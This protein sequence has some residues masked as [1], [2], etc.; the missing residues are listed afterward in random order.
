MRALHDLVEELRLVGPSPD[1][2]DAILRALAESPPL[3]H[4][5]DP[6]PLVHYVE[7]VPGFRTALYARARATPT[8]HFLR[9]L[10]RCVDAADDD[11][12]AALVIIASYAADPDLPAPL[13]DEARSF[14]AA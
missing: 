13:R 7:T 1:H 14:L 12:D 8:M 5:G 4:F 6:G 3:T 10:G 2:V 11:S 9:M